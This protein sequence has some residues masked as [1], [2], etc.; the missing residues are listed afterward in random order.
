MSGNHNFKLDI[1][2]RKLFKLDVSNFASLLSWILNFRQK[3]NI[4]IS[5]F[6]LSTRLS[7]TLRIRKI[8]VNVTSSLLKLRTF[9][10]YNISLK[11]ILITSILRQIMSLPLTIAIKRIRIIPI[12]QFL[13]PFVAT[14]MKIP[15]IGITN[16]DV[17][18]QQLAKLNEYDAS[19]LDT[20]DGSALS[21][22]DYGE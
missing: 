9:F 19:A 8:S 6:R 11:K 15:K 7:L 21:T 14:T 22:L 4:T 17:I 1:N 12:P 10:T 18:V 5:S 13:I 20:I 16:I 3:I 2:T